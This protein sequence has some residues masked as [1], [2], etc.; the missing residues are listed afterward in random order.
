[1]TVK[2]RVEQAR[3]LL[4]EAGTEYAIGSQEASDCYN[5]AGSLLARLAEDLERNQRE[6][7]ND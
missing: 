6:D 7:E 2:E 1:M 5:R 4:Y 3:W